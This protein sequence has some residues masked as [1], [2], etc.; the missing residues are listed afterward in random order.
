[1]ENSF[2]I[3]EVRKVIRK[4]KDEKCVIYKFTNKI[5][6]KIYIGK[7]KGTIAS[8]FIRYNYDVNHDYDRPILNSIRLYGWSNF[9]V[10]I[11]QQCNSIEELNEAEKFWI[12]TLN[13][14]NKEIGYNLSEGG[15]RGNPMDPNT[16][17]AL[18]SS[19][20]GKSLTK[21][22]RE[23]ISKGLKGVCL[24]KKVS[25]EAR[26]K[27][28]KS[29]KGKKLSKERIEQISINSSG[30]SNGNY[31]LINKN[32][33][34]NCFINGMTLEE[35]ENT[36]KICKSTIESK[37]KELFNMTLVEFRKH[38]GI[39]PCNQKLSEKDV[40]E[41]KIKNILGFP[42]TELAKEYSTTEANISCIVRGK[43]W[44]KI[45]ISDFLNKMEKKD[46]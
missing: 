5:N 20:K 18:A 16:L 6:G 42:N 15:D 17:K 3:S 30:S 8:R 9:V 40:R 36:L 23:K 46:V 31:I 37:V 45:D 39:K 34:L 43:S 19:R 10:E 41:I 33:L 24:G 4:I 21:E 14:R 26:A 2:N 13:T 35:I 44:K 38:L 7:T 29:Q 12:K 1:M 11:Q 32:D 22:H 27:M 25:D 28:S